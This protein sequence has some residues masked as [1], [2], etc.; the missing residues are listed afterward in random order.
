M[1]DSR[2]IKNLSLKNISSTDALGNSHEV[3][4]V[5]WP[6]D[7]VIYKSIFVLLTLSFPHGI[8]F[9]KMHA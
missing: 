5:F 7:A 4:M 2:N 9:K 6:G 8:S 3:L 1:F